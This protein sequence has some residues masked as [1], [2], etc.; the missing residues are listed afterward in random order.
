M[1]IAVFICSTAGCLLAVTVCIRYLKRTGFW[2]EFRSTLVAGIR[3]NWPLAATIVF[4]VIV[5]VLFYFIF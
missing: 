4:G 5:S 2:Y 3:E 1:G